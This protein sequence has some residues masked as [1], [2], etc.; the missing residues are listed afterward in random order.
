MKISELEDLLGVS[1]STVRYYEDLG[2]LSPSRT[3]KGSRD[4]SDEEAQ[5]LQ[6]IIVL[7]KLGVG[8]PE[9]RDLTDDK[10]DLHDALARSMDSLRAKQSESASAIEICEE[11]DSEASDFA[12]IDSPKYLKSIY[13][14]EQKGAHF[15]A[16]EE[17]SFRQLNLAITMLGMLAGIPVLQNKQFSEHSHDP[18]PDDI[19]GNKKEGDE[20]D[21][22]G[23]VLSKGG[24]RKAILIAVAVL[25]GMMLIGNGSMVWGGLGCAGKFIADYNRSGIT[26]AAPDDDELAQIA[27]VDPEA[28]AAR[29]M[30]ELLRFHTQGGL[31]LTLKVSDGGAW[32]ELDRKEISAKEGYLFVTGTPSSEIVLH[33]IAD[34]K[35]TKHRIKINDSKCDEDEGAMI[36]ADQLP[37][38]KEQ[39]IALFFR[40]SDAWSEAEDIM[41][42]YL[43]YDILSSAP[44]DGCYAVTARDR[45]K[46]SYGE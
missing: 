33:V 46:K 18:I 23:D 34:H 22:I 38:N 45:N 30:Y 25:F 24:K 29:E 3:G 43:F 12:H 35:S 20:Y 44:S 37:L 4:Y 9:I 32:T 16:T 5:L 17:I 26:V 7:R 14:A 36:D 6:K 8:I 40:D 41:N 19:R 21:T 27:A 42:S 13:E 15:A 39:A 1:G 11:I 28:V 2:F 10:A 31:V